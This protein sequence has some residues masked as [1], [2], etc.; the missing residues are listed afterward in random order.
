M[1]E[2]LEKDPAAMQLPFSLEPGDQVTQAFALWAASDRIAEELGKCC[3]CNGPTFRIV[4]I[5]SAKK[6]EKR[7]ALCGKH[8]AISL[9]AFPHLNSQNSPD[10][11]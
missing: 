2:L 7:A 8:F 1:K 4:T 5:T 10:P 9:K 6:L 3:A 11:A